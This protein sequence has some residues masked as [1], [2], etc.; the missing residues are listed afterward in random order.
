MPRLQDRRHVVD[1][2]R[3]PPVTVFIDR[4]DHPDWTTAAL[5]DPYS[6][7]PGASE[8]HGLAFSADGVLYVALEHGAIA[9]VP[10]PQAQPTGPIVD[11]G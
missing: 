9:R 4:H 3:L 10:V 8:P 5:A 2:G 6:L 1:P 7:G 11:A